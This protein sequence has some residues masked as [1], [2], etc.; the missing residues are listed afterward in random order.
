MNNRNFG[1][2][3]I[4][5]SILLFVGDML[6]YGHFGNASE[7]SKN[8]QMV[9]QNSSQ[10]RLFIGGIFGPIGAMLYIAGFWHIYLNTKQYSRFVSI[11][12][13][14]CLSC[15]MF[16]GGTYHAI[17]TVRM[18]LLKYPLASADN[19][20]LFLISFNAYFKTIF[21]IS[22]LIGYFGGILLAILILIHKSIYPRWV[23]IVNPAILFLLTPLIRHISYPFGSILFG[24]YI[25]IVLFVFLT[26]SVI[27]TWKK[28]QD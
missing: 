22:L 1:L 4:F 18:L 13:F 7:F 19:S 24:G 21:N 23:V 5:A 12:I 6:L 20:N 17:W 15:M 14:L 11:I 25:N 8:I 16:F 10:A 2:I 27:A 28:Q 3:G 26:I 9:A